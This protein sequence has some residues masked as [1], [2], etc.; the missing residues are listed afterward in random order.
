MQVDSTEVKVDK[1]KDPFKD[2]GPAIVGNIVSYTSSSKEEEVV[3]EVSPKKDE[4]TSVTVEE[5]KVTTPTSTNI[6]PITPIFSVS[7]ST[8][9]GHIAQV[10]SDDESKAQTLLSSLSKLLEKK[11]YVKTMEKTL[12][13][14]L[15]KMQSIITPVD[16][17]TD[18]Q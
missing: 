5:A 16:T 9:F 18:V 8:P 17:P 12:A 14:V 6:T 2:Y 13:F 1:V 4:G 15:D 10:P 7:P 3:K 11:K